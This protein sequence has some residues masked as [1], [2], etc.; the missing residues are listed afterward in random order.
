MQ[1]PVV[2][3]KD[4]SFPSFRVDERSIYR[5]RCLFR[6]TI[7]ST[8]VLCDALSSTADVEKGVKRR[9]G[10][11]CIGGSTSSEKLVGWGIAE[12]KV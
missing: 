6:L 11:V 8:F 7:R 9:G 1:V 2:V 4:N 5:D 3:S 12:K 10:A